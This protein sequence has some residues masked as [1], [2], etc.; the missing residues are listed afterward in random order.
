MTIQALVTLPLA[1]SVAMAML[2]QEPQVAMVSQLLVPTAVT[3]DAATMTNTRS[4]LTKNSSLQRHLDAHL[5]LS[6]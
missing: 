3:P 5:H 6:A 4:K 2:H 1:Q